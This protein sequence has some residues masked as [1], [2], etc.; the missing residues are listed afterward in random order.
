MVQTIAYFTIRNP[1]SNI[2][3]AKAEE[4]CVVNCGFG[5]AVMFNE[6]VDILNEKLGTN[7][8]A[9]YFDNPYKDSYQA[10]TECDMALAKEK[11]KFEPKFDIRAGI[12]NYYE[13]GFLMEK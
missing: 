1:L 12:T 6:L 8:K 7:R 10:Y 9:E 2:L 3:A 4:S 5:V 11:I 13:S